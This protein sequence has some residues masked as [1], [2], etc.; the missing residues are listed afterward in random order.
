VTVGELLD[1]I[2][3]AEQRYG[4]ELRHQSILIDGHGAPDVD[5]APGRA[6]RPRGYGADE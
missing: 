3:D 2:A 5:I 6:I 1:A 4:I